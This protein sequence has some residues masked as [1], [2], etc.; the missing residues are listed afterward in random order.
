[1]ES[2]K[3]KEECCESP[4]RDFVNHWNWF[5]IVMIVAALVLPV[6]VGVPTGAGA[7][8]I[9]ATTFG[10]IAAVLF[11]KARIEAYIAY[12]V[13]LV[14]YA[15]VAY[16]ES[17][18]G[19]IIFAV[20]VMLPITIYGI[21]NWGRHRRHDDAK[22][23]VALITNTSVREFGLI[24]GSQV[25]MGVGYFFL[26]RWL[27]TEFLVV[28]TITLVVGIVAEYLV[29]RRSRWALYA[30]IVKELAAITLWAFVIAEGGT[31]VIVIILIPIF[32]IINDTY[33]A[34]QWRR[35]QKRQQAISGM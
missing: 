14:L 18:Y 9:L 8:E 30:H 25:V 28:S 16:T 19:E 34:I 4:I 11:A 17:V 33:G 2:I 23:S 15:I 29:A 12:V 24:V 7:I 31:N 22:G 1:M 6:S 20:F 5:E 21:M 13:S 10:A 32:C 26:L 27:G 3:R 35:L